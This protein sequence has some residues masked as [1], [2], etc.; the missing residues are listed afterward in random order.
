M[1]YIN[2]KCQCT[3]KINE[4]CKIIRYLKFSDWWIMFTFIMIKNNESNI[5]NSLCMEILIGF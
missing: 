4:S 3:N 5:T 2:E 1:K